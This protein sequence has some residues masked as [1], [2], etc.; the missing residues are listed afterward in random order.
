MAAPPTPQIFIAPG[1]KGDYNADS[2]VDTADYVVWRKN[3]GSMTDLAADGDHDGIVGSNDYLVWQSNFG[4]VADTGSGN[5]QLSA[6]ME[7]VDEEPPSTAEHLN[8]KT[9]QLG[10]ELNRS[11]AGGHSKST[12]AKSQPFFFHR[13]SHLL[14]MLT[15]DSSGDQ[16]DELLK[17]FAVDLCGATEAMNQFVTLD[18]AFAML[19]SEQLGNHRF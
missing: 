14:V 11:L 5:G 18:E 9:V 8:L 17:S 13:D 10:P 2:V 1:L 12:I 3:V 15:P 19:K 4:A 7:S 16:D 6:L